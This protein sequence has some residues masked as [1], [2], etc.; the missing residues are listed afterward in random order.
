MRIGIDLGGTKIE[1][2]ALD[3]NG[4][5]LA[6]K[7]VPT[8]KGD[9]PATLMAVRDLV[10]A[11]EAETAQQ[12]SV[13]IGMPGTLSQV[14]G[15]VKNSNSTCLNHMPFSED[16]SAALERPVRLAN[17]A[18]CFTLSEATDG[19]GAGAPIVFGV[20]LGTGVGGGIAING[21]LISGPNGIAGE[22]GHNPLP[23]LLPDEFPGPRCYCGKEG[24]IESWC[25]GPAFET[26]FETTENEKLTAAEI[27]ARARD[28]HRPAKSAI[29]RYSDRVARALSHVINL[30]DPHVI[31]L[32]GGMSNIDEIYDEI[33]A[34]WGSYV[35]SDS[36]E[37]KLLRNIHGDSGGVRGAAWLW[38]DR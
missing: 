21:S 32:G 35:F 34:R 24:C 17:D 31:V 1:G 7:R 27:V 3:K 9:Y 16:I 28:G 33:T 36:V 4:N 26:E 2:V 18:D 14:T 29:R 22:W 12:G 30:L 13:G 15:R 20:I 6:R 10:L 38:P 8:P 23:R 37:T 19:A 11:L 25:S 5:E